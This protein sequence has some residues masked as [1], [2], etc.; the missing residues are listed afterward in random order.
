V[1]IACNPI[2]NKSI[3]EELT[4]EELETAVKSDSL[5]AKLYEELCEQKD[6][7]SETQKVYFKDLTYRRVY[8]FIKLLY[9]Y[10]EDTM[11]RAQ[12]EKEWEEEWENTFGKDLDIVKDTV[13]YWENHSLSRFAKVELSNFSYINPQEAYI[14]FK[15]T[16]L[17]GS[18]ERIE[19]IFRYDDD[20]WGEEIQHYIYSDP[21]HKTIE[22]A[23]RIDPYLYKDIT[24]SEFLQMYDWS[25]MI[26]NI[27]K[28]G[29]D[30]SILTL[31]IPQEILAILREWTPE[32]EEAVAKLFNPSYMSRDTYIQNKFEEEFRDYDSLC[33]EFF[34]YIE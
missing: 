21:I 28:N 12:L 7:F 26:T 3:F 1:F 16:P 13:K 19:F 14:H 4:Q 29:V 34:D 11:Q 18:L 22:G 9:S 32:N 10:A 6:T 15:I 30:Y 25:I 33:C 17:M 31:G 27:R 5:F 23:W 8:K 24:A 2:P 20:F